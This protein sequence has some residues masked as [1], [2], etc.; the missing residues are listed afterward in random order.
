ME[1]AV[2]PPDASLVQHPKP[3]YRDDCDSSLRSE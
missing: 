2:P 1:L 3:L